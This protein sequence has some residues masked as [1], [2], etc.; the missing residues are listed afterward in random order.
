MPILDKSLKNNHERTDLSDKF[1]VGRV[2]V[3][4][5]SVGNEPVRPS[6]RGAA[7][8]ARSPHSGRRSPLALGRSLPQ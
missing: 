8:P 5:G 4:G 2:E 1:V 3:H 7:I 6:R